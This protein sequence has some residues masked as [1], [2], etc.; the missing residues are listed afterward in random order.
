M[1]GGNFLTIYLIFF[2]SLTKFSRGFR[3]LNTVDV[4]IPSSV[5]KYRHDLFLKGKPELL[6][7]MSTKRKKK[8]DKQKHKHK[9][10]DKKEKSARRNDSEDEDESETEDK[11]KQSKSKGKKRKRTL[12]AQRIQDELQ[13]SSEGKEEVAAASDAA[14]IGREE[15]KTAF[16]NELQSSPAFLAARWPRRTDQDEVAESKDDFAPDAMRQQIQHQLS[17]SS[18]MATQRLSDPQGIAAALPPS[19]EMMREQALRLQGE[20]QAL[21]RQI[22]QNR[23]QGDLRSLEQRLLLE[24]L[25]ATESVQQRS[26]ALSLLHQQDRRQSLT[27]DFMP[28]RSL[29]SFV[30]TDALNLPG[31]LSLQN[32]LL[33]MREAASHSIAP[34]GSSGLGS[35]GNNLYSTS[36]LGNLR[37]TGVGT[38]GFPSNL[39]S[40]FLGSNYGAGNSA[41]SDNRSALQLQQQLGG[42]RL[43]SGFNSFG[44]LGSAAGTSQSNISDTNVSLRLQMQLEQLQQQQQRQFGIP[45][46]VGVSESNQNQTDSQLLA[47]LRDRQRLQAE[48]LMIEQ[49]QRQNRQPP[50]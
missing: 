12:E 31:N 17:L 32:R 36:N 33:A 29:G 30:N 49:Q 35:G 44:S 26:L 28:Q 11:K 2:V 50:E 19:P 15:E 3:K 21:L 37:G 46:S 13:M 7:Q 48:L 5:V 43:G 6:K 8:K 1:Q 34:S 38:S 20:Q 24:S 4:T 14:E 10:Q 45:P 16:F 39:A 25:F 23:P 22:G 41:T 40:N 27:S 18:S 47:L 42:G 9:D